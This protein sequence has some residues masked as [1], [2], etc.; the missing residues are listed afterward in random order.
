MTPPT[1]ASHRRYSKHPSWLPQLL[2]IA[3]DA[4]IIFVSTLL[5]YWARF[6]GAVFPEFRENIYFVSGTATLVFITGFIIV[7]LYRH[8]WRYA[9]ASTYMRLFLSIVG[10]TAVLSLLTL[11]VHTP[12][13]G[14][15]AP[16]GVL[17]LLAVFELVGSAALRAYS[18]VNAHF[19]EVAAAPREAKRVL[20][21]GA[22]DAGSIMLR[23]VAARPE[24]GLKIVGF[25]DDNPNKVGKVLRGVSVYGPIESLAQIAKEL[26][27]EKIYVAMPSATV[28]QQRR[29]LDICAT[30]GLP[31]L[32]A[33]SLARTMGDF[34]TSDFRRVATEDLLGRDAVSLDLDKIAHT[35]TDKVVLITGAAGS[36]GSELARQVLRFGPRRIVLLDVDESRLY[37][38]YLDLRKDNPSKP[39][40]TICNIRNVNKLQNVFAEHRPN[41]VIHAAAYK[42]VPLMEISP[43]EAI[44]TNVLGTINVL[45]A[46]EKFKPDRFVLIS[47]DK[48]VE[49]TSV[50]GATKAIA[51]RLTFAAC[52]RGVP[53]CAVRFGNV[54]GSRG[55][56]VPIF[57][58]RLRNH[59][60]LLVTHPDMTR[61]FMTISEAS[62]LVLQAQSLDAVG[63]LFVLDM[64]E[65]VKIVDLA[66]KMISLSGTKVGVE[67]TGLRPGEKLYEILHSHA[68]SLLP[69]SA[70]KVMTV[71]LCSTAV[72]SMLLIDQLVQAG[73]QRSLSEI[74]RLLESI[75]PDF[76]PL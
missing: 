30:S 68:E 19:H 6:G 3:M 66:T 18:R 28:L 71:N 75:I 23:D 72:P 26:D 50:M 39:V 69:T 22:G 5:A 31:T 70:E 4:L 46:C 21:V 62:L 35:I 1:D 12:D 2:Y 37:E 38:T 64:G 42:H 44:L 47:T 59:E 58:A 60:P 45:E 55:S 74:R 8:V 27:A 54:L 76:R 41:L 14:R 16:L 17:A 43:D 73:E 40:M 49:P 63:H 57:E 56:V 32:I 48:A 53:A 24:Y 10:S 52:R 65:P 29:V 33:P 13:G 9:G 15:Y 7:G 67:F 11:S 36:I 20:V 25:L 34:N 51:E 61:Y